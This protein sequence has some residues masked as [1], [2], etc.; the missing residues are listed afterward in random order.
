VTSL[1]GTIAANMFNFELKNN[2]D[3]VIDLPEYLNQ[4]RLLIVFFRGAWCNYCKKQ[5]KEI[6][7]SISE[8]DKLNIKIIALSCDNKLNSNLLK[9]FLKLDY[10][11]LSDND[12]KV[13][14]S[15]NFRTVYKGKEVSKPAIMLFDNNGTELY[16]YVGKE[17]DDRIETNEL[18]KQLS[19]L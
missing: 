16:R 8:F 9:E 19:N 14:D 7:S 6:Q 12:Y 11:V 18:L 17:Y 15:F 3:S 2:D 5:L 4:K 10:P 13:I 1:I